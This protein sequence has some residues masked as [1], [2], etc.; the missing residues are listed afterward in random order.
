MKKTDITISWFLLGFLTLITAYIFIFPML[1]GISTSL[2]SEVEFL[3]VLNWGIIPNDITFEHF[4]YMF[5]KSSMMTWYI[6]SLMTSI[7]VTLLVIII[8]MPCGYALSQIQFTGKTFIFVCVVLSIMVPGTALVIALFIFVAELRLI[9]T[10]TGIILPQVISPVCVI[11]YKQFFDQVPKEL[12]EASLIDGASEFQILLRVYMPLN[13]GITAALALVTFIGAW[14]NFFWP[15]IMTTKTEMYTIT[16]GMA[17]VDEAWGV[18]NAYMMAVAMA[19]SLPVVIAY[20]IFQRRIT[21]AIML[22]SGIKG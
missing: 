18:K 11:V 2:K 3:D 17:Q 7:G 20:I 16:A 4:F 14:N 19:A 1:W 15:F 22:T 8:S 9:N 6:N 13:W 12:R 21:Q 5:T 10:W